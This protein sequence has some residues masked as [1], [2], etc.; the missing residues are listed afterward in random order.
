MKTLKEINKA[1]L[2]YSDQEPLQ[3]AFREGARYALTGKYYKPVELF[4]QTIQDAVFEGQNDS[5]EDWWQMYGKKRGK[6]KAKQKWDKLTVEQQTACLIATPA[7]VAS[8]PDRTYRKDPL[9]YLNG[10]CW[11]DEIILKQNH[12]QRRANNLAAKAAR[13]LGSDYQG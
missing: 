3:D 10:E 11:N 12:E 2:G 9:T 4:N 1:A 8:T 5:F 13:I 7:Y 6:K